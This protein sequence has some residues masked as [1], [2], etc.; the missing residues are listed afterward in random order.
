MKRRFLIIIGL[1]CIIGTVQLY[2]QAE[3]IDQM[4]IGL[5]YGFNEDQSGSGLN[6]N[7]DYLLGAHIHSWDTAILAGMRYNFNDV[8]DVGAQAEYF[9]GYST[10]R[11]LSGFG[12]LLGGGVQIIPGVTPY[13]KT[14][15]FWHFAT[16]VK[17][18]IEL[19]YHFNG[20]F[21]VG[22]KLSTPSLTTM[23]LRLNHFQKSMENRSQTNN[24]G[25]NITISIA[26]ETGYEVHYVYISPSSDDNWGS[27]K[28][29]SDEVLRDGAFR[30]FSLPPLNVT[31][32]YDIRIV[33][34]DG[35]TYTKMGVTISPNM[36]IR[37]VFD[38]ID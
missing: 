6:F 10:S 35:D 5:G 24:Q 15:G 12:V 21:S 11:K 13:V 20:Q 14:G 23:F 3:F 17:A 26:N 36:I 19:D 30:R 22:L 8:F 37:F 38:D 9:F 7:F 1:L 34:L 25:N 18:G 28:L 2:A 16:M 31:R 29:G 33:D 27:D 32:T 4:G